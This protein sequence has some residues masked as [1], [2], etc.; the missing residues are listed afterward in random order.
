MFVKV[1]ETVISY[2]KTVDLSEDSLILNMW[3][4]FSKLMPL[5]LIYPKEISK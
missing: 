4:A 2:I 5:V 3:R 1:K